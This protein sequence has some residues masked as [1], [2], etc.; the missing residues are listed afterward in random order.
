MDGARAFASSTL[1]GIALLGGGLSASAQTFQSAPG[2][3][4]QGAPFNDSYTEQVDFA[5]VDLD[6]DWDAVFA[7]GGN[8]CPDDD[9]LWINQGGAQGGTLGV[10]VDETATR[11]PSVL[12][13]GRDVEFLDFDGDLDLDLHAVNTSIPNNQASRWWTN[14]GGAQGGAPGFYIDETAS[15]WVNLAGPGSSVAPSQVLPGG[16][17]VDFSHDGDFADL[18]AD[19]DLDLVH[20][21][22]GIIFTARIPT[23]LFLN[24]G[25][26]YFAEFNPS[27]FQLPGQ[28]IANGDPGLWCEGTHRQ[29]TL[30]ATGAQCDIALS[31]LDVEVGD[32]DG[33][34][35]I[36]LL[37]GAR[38]D[39]P[40][41]FENRREE[42]G[43]VLSLR[44]VTSASFPPGYASSAVAHFHQDLGDVD[45]D[46]DLDIYGVDWIKAS[47]SYDD[48]ALANNGSG[49]FAPPVSIA[50]SGDFEDDADLVD[51]DLDGDLDALV[52]GFQE[53]AFANNGAG[54]F[55]PIANAVPADNSISLD[56]D[57][58]DLD[59][60]GDL[61]AM[62]ASDGGLPNTYLRNTFGGTDVHAPVLAALEQ[63]A[64]RT[65]SGT[66][67]AVRVELYDNAP[68]Y[69]LWYD[70]VSLE[71]R[72]NSG[73]FQSAPMKSSGG[74]VFRGEI[75]GGLVGTVSYRVRAIDEHGNVGLSSTKS[76]NAT[77]G[78]ATTPLVYCTAKLNSLGCLP[79]IG[80]SGVP[81]A[82]AGIGFAVSA[83]NV[84]NNKSGLLFYG[85][86]GPAASP[87]QN[88]TLCV[89]T[90]IKRTPAVTSGGNPS[91]ANDCS[92][93]F[94]IDMNAF[95]LG[96]LGGSPL[97]ALRTAGTVV[98]CQWWGRDPGFA[99]PNNTTLSDGLAYSICP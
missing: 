48:V 50:G 91:P 63:A 38:A 11:L 80:S 24:D 71:Y 10:F 87:F 18:D 76:Y 1:A 53:L 17:F 26:G 83:T 14:Q 12:G 94:S 66:P 47:F 68:Y 16:G 98:N 54:A 27:G 35:D 75:P 40:R 15:R 64:N 5:D 84:R 29:N 95:A 2:L 36:D 6:G 46:L 58:A 61:D 8:C 45:G 3:I 30:N 62:V 90:P 85:V 4:P 44:D 81:S 23:R 55:T 72:L 19:G 97:A 22:Y 60:D 69:V 88:G 65:A 37:L 25:L 73:P 79:S 32:F 96:H 59:G 82:T 9:R 31:S 77:S 7:D 70:A 33:D 92:G 78:C 67:T 51:L 57:A 13:T 21:S 93:V 42:N 20:S 56:V 89:Q 86:N 99:P 74:Q 52:S 41:R 34:L 49:L 43:G 39:L 28:E